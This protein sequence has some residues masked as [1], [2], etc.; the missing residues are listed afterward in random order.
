MPKQEQAASGDGILRA[1]CDLGEYKSL[2]YERVVLL[3]APRSEK[4]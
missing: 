1:T 4:R 3:P 2:A